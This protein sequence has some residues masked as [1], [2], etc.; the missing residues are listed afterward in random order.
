MTT[1]KKNQFFWSDPHKNEVM[2]TS[3]IEI[4]ELLN[5]DDMIT[6]KT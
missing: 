1:P 6:P 4:L 3:L 2:I 5:F